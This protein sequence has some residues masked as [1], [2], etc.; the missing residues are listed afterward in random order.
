[1]AEFLEVRSPTANHTY[2]I[3]VNA[4]KYISASSK[5][6]QCLVHFDQQSLA[7]GI[8]AQS[9]AARGGNLR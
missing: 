5:D 3:N 9:F 1:M 8:S 7:I 6:E 2:F 4:V